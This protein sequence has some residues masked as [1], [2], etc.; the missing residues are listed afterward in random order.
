MDFRNVTKLVD[1]ILEHIPCPRCR[2]K[3][4]GA[5]LDVMSADEESLAFQFFCP[6]CDARVT[7]EG[8]LKKDLDT[9]PERVQLPIVPIRVL[10]PESVRGISEQLNN[11]HGSDIRELLS[12]G[13]N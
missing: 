6:H 13:G 12:D 7:M 5:E 4:T 11:F 1:E 9:R 8:L 3:L 10:S 2:Q